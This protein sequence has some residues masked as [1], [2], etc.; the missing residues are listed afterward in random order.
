MIQTA[1]RRGQK[2]GTRARRTPRTTEPRGVK[3][4]IY[5]DAATN[6]V[7]A[8][9][10]ERLGWSES[11]TTEALLGLALLPYRAPGGVDEPAV[12]RRLVGL[13]LERIETQEGS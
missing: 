4:S 12:A 9:L 6:A 5:L 3:R 11:R 1:P 7:M 2:P 10:A 8:R 13:E